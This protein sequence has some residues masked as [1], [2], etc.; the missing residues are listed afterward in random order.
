MHRFEKVTRSKSVL[1]VE[2][3]QRP[4]KG[5]HELKML[6]QGNRRNGER[7]EISHER[8]EKKLQYFLRVSLAQKF[9]RI[10]LTTYQN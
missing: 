8:Y 2:E 7:I 5:K 4:K 1:C 10:F 6:P 3:F 9:Q